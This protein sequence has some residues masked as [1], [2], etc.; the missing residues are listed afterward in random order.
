M[1]VPSGLNNARKN[2]AIERFLM[3]K[4][5]TGFLIKALCLHLLSKQAQ[6]VQPHPP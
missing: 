2:V 1:V 6:S 5:P 4:I 3:N